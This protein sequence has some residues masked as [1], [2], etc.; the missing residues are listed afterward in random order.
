MASDPA[1]PLLDFTLDLYKQ[2][3]IENK[4][5]ANILFSPF[6]VAAALSM[7]LAGAR[8]HTAEQIERTMHLKG[9]TAHKYFADILPKIEGYAP[10]VTLQL[11]NRLYSDEL[12]RVLP[13]YTSLLAES[14]KTTMKSVDFQNHWDASRRQIN[15]WVQEVTRS[16][17]KDL[18]PE[19]SMDTF[20]ALVIVNAIYFKGPWNSPFDPED[21]HTEKFHE[22]EERSKTVNM[23]H[24][25]AKFRMNNCNVHNVSVL[26]IPY[27]GKNTS[28]VILLPK[29][30]D[31]L[32]ALEKMLTP[33]ALKEILNGLVHKTTVVLSLPSFKLEQTTNLKKTLQAMGIHDLF[34][35]QSDL[36][37]ISDR[38]NLRVSTAVHK[39]FVEVNEEGTEAA[40][41]SDFIVE[42][43]SAAILPSFTVDHPFLFVI[44]SRDPDIILFMGSVRH[45]DSAG[46]L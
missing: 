41:A 5:K 38:K 42:Q 8:H 32:S 14:Y 46:T 44:R 10:N 17:I 22:T 30:I 3:L 26:E 2:L 37:G 33:S 16:R 13:A 28:M 23:M 18:F 25:E 20:T 7:T 31:G 40:A 12:I 43:L 35:K 21:T 27:K 24:K 15:A 29:K 36:S 4:G 45:V 39:A 6:S 34:L 11:A 1:D 9:A 19:G